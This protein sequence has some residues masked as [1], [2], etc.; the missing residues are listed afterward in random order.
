MP[1]PFP[2]PQIN[3][4]IDVIKYANTV[5]DSM[6]TVLMV[7]CMS[8]I[9]FLIMKS[10][11]YRISLSLAIS[12]MITLVFATFLFIVNLLSGTIVIIYLALTVLFVIWAMIDE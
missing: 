12:S 9:I 1:R 2:E 10:K 11:Y 3:E 6:A 7:L 4:T 5:T 8:I